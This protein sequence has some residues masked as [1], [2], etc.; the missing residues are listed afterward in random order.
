MDEF[1]LVW[2]MVRMVVKVR[3]SS[4]L[5]T[6]CI[7][8]VHDMYMYGQDRQH[9][10][11]RLP[12]LLDYPGVVL[13]AACTHPGMVLV[14]DPVGADGHALPAPS[15]QE[16]LAA[17]ARMPELEWQASANPSEIPLR[18]LCAGWQLSHNHGQG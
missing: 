18:P 5:Y 6:A 12:P 7:L 3:V 16:A 10:H 4:Y 1:C 9:A 17:V 2:N 8:H 13:V 11:Q 15:I 14:Q